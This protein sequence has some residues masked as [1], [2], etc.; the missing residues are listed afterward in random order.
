MKYLTKIDFFLTEAM[1]AY[2]KNYRPKKKKKKKHPIITS[3]IYK[4]TAKTPGD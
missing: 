1:H 2:Y 4:I 3:I